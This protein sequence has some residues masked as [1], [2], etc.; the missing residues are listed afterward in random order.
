MHI[1]AEFGEN[2]KRIREEKGLTQQTLADYL[3]VTRQAVSRWEGGSRYPD[4]MTA[5][6]MSQFL[7]VSLDELLSDDDLKS[8]VEKNAILDSV[9]SKR[10]QIVLISLAFMSSLVVSILYLCNYFYLCNCFV[11]DTLIIKA[12][13]ELVKSILLTII[14]GYGTCAAIYD[15]I[16]PRIALFISALFFG[17]AIVTGITSIFWDERVITRFVLLGTVVLNTFVLVICIRFFGSKKIISPNLLYIIAGLYALS[18][19][20]FLSIRFSLGFPPEILREL[21]IYSI[22]PSM[23]GL[24]LIILLLFMAYVLDKKRKLAAR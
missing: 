13:I 15:K 8:Y 14:L 5:K 21:F 2:L 17:T 10:V 11:Q 18:E 4:L 23:E 9:V 7:E 24:L 16:N 3:F 20:V 6:K 19:I 12:D 1:M 22:F